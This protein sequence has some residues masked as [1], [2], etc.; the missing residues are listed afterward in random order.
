[1]LFRAHTHDG[2]VIEVSLTV[3]AASYF[4][5]TRPCRIFCWN[6]AA[7]VAT[8]AG[9]GLALPPEAGARNTSPSRLDVTRKE[10]EFVFTTTPDAQP[11]QTVLPHSDPNHVVLI[12]LVGWK[13]V[14]MGGFH[15]VVV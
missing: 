7:N 9:A 11:G 4:L 6:R 2:I 1:M 3:H 13:V 5:T 14:K 8:P 12:R 10:C 15:F